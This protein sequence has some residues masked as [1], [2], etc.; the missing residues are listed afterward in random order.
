MTAALLVQEDLCILQKSGDEHVLT[1]AALCFPASW[2]LSEKYMRPLIG[3]HEPVDSYDDNIA[4]RVQRM[5]DGIRPHRPLWRFNA[6]WYDDPGLF[7]PRSALAPRDVT[8]AH[9]ARFLRSERQSLSRLPETDAV[10]FSIH[11]F[12][13]DKSDWII[14]P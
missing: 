6:L 7:Q 8:D 3:I 14:A 12:V 10:V 13:L 9:T 2:R 4:R 11:T 5:F 1:A